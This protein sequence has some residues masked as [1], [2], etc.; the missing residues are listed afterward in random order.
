M[1]ILINKDWGGF[2]LSELAHERLIELGITHYKD[3]KEI[4]EKTVIELL[5]NNDKMNTLSKNITLLAKFNAADDIV[6][7]V[8]KFV[9]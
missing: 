9:R 2:G 4:L 8:L 5:E 6:S 7:E 1:K 3:F